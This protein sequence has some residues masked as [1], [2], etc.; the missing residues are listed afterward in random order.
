MDGCEKCGLVE[1]DLEFGVGITL[2][3][4]LM[5]PTC[6]QFIKA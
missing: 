4:N 3:L 5:I 1:F 2:A 6:L